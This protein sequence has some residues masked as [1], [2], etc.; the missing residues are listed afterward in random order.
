MKKN[1]NVLKTCTACIYTKDT[2]LRK[3]F[4]K[5]KTEQTD[6]IKSYISLLYA[7]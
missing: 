6:L 1:A 5:N 4:K 3:A 7:F 2:G